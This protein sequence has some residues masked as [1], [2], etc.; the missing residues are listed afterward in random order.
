MYLLKLNRK[1]AIVS[2]ETIK[3]IGYLGLLAAVSFAIWKIVSKVMG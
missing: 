3:W 2:D 1:G